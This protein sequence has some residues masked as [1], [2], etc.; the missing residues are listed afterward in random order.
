MCK[1][2]VRW[3]LISGLEA[4]SVS[5]SA[6]ATHRRDESAASYSS[7]GCTPASPVSASLAG[8]IFDHRDATVNTHKHIGKERK[9]F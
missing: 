4:K 3:D 6:P 7:M 9:T 5:Y 2:I 1:S 8:L